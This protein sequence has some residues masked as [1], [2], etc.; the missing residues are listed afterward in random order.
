MPFLF[1]SKIFALDFLFLPYPFPFPA[2]T[3]MSSPHELL[4]H[5]AENAYLSLNP[6]L[7]DCKEKNSLSAGNTASHAGGV[8]ADRAGKATH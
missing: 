7:S 3:H 2:L 8:R 6:N 5:G 1:C 4:F